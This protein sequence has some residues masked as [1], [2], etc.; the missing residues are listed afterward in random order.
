M[1]D[2]HIKNAQTKILLI[3]EVFQTH[4]IQGKGGINLA[5]DKK[6]ISVQATKNRSSKK[7]PK[8]MFN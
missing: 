4:C 7:L 2:V 1:K 5:K 8:S 6:R 3:K